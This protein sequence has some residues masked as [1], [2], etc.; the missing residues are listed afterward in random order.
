METHSVYD[1]DCELLNCNRNIFN[2]ATNWCELAAVWRNHRAA[3]L[4]TLSLVTNGNMH[5]IGQWYYS[6]ATQHMHTLM[7]DGI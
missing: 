6:A 3:H 7:A 2:A 5:E 1:D 4:A